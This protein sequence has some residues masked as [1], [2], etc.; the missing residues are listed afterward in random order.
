MG[1]RSLTYFYETDGKTPF[2]A[3]YRQ[4]DGYPTGHGK[5]IASFMNSKTMVNG[6]NDAATQ[7]NGMGC[8]AAQIV[9]R[10]KGDSAG[11]IYLCS[12]ELN[13]DKWQ[14]FEYHIYPDKVVIKDPTDVIFTG[15][16]REFENFCCVEETVD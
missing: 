16:W 2:V 1:T 12:P 7:F 13:Q 3:F 8:M 6:Y 11:G 15:S 9:G 4:F 10:L 14:E 5:D